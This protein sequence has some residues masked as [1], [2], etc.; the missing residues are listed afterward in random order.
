VAEDTDM[1]IMIIFLFTLFTIKKQR[2]L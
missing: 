2:L 1:D